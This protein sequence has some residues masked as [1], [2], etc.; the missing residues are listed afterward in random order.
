VL[1]LRVCMV[2]RR[3]PRGAVSRTRE[4]LSPLPP[5]PGKV[6]RVR[7]VIAEILLRGPPFTV[8]PVALG[9]S[10]VAFEKAAVAS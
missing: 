9:R 5:A 6:E 1:R 8:S 4:G 2:I 10:A 3:A 7:V